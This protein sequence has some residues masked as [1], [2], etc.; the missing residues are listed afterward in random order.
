MMHVVGSGDLAH[1]FAVVAPPDRL[2]ALMWSEFRLAPH[3][4]ASR[5]RPR[6]SFACPTAD[7]VALE[8]CLM[9]C[10]A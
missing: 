7:K 2:G 10:T 8:L 1:G 4:H 9:R 5:L 3:L 6:P